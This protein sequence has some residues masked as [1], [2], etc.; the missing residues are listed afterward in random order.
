MDL[1]QYELECFIKPYIRAEKERL[2]WER[3]QQKR[4]KITHSPDT[5]VQAAKMLADGITSEQVAK[6]LHVNRSTLWR[7][8]E[9]EL[10]QK[11]YKEEADSKAAERI[12]EEIRQMNEFLNRW[13]P[14]LN[15]PNQHEAQRA[16]I[17]IMNSR[18]GKEI[19]KGMLR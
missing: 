15:S 13:L 4:A 17:M 2:K 12:T 8:K 7:W 3:K 9:R 1:K 19:E 6:E 11:A 14:L 5:V 10:F 16:A 18:Y